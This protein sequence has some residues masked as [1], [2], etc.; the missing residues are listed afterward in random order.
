MIGSYWVEQ[1][2]DCEYCFFTHSSDNCFGCDGIKKGSFC[3]LNKRCSEEEYHELRE[4][5]RNELKESGDYGL[6]F[7]PSI[8]PFAYNETIAQDYFPLSKEE[9]LTQGY[10]WHDNLPMTTGAETLSVEFIPDHIAQV[11]ASI[12]KDI[13]ACVECK[14][15]Y[16]VTPKEL[17]FYQSMSLPI[18]RLCFGCRH[19]DRIKRRGPMKLFDRICDKCKKDIRTTFA[20]D[21]PEIVYCTECYQETV[22]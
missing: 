8:A 1:G 7:P 18:P 5:I 9:A 14:R 12:T 11:T 6:F 2:H 19:T 22:I 17:A 13:L 15:N 20:P 10:R 16:K 21:R 3:I 4:H